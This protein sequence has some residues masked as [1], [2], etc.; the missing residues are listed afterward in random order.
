MNELIKDEVDVVVDVK[1]VVRVVVDVVRVV[2]DALVEDVR[3]V[4]VLFDVRVVL[5]TDVPVFVFVD[6][7]VVHQDPHDVDFRLPVRS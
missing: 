6:E 2:V 3:M 5:F 4:D 7:H 1:D